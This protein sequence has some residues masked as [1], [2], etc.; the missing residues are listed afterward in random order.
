MAPCIRDHIAGRGLPD[1]PRAAHSVPSAGRSRAASPSTIAAEV[2]VIVAADIAD[3]NGDSQ[4][5]SCAAPA[6]EFQRH[7]SGQGG[8]HDAPAGQAPVLTSRLSKNGDPNEA[9]SLQ[10]RQRRAD[11][12]PARGHRC[13]LPRA[14][15]AGPAQ[16]TTRTSCSRCR[17]S[18]R[19]SKQHR[20]RLR[21]AAAIT[22]TATATAM[23]TG[24]PWAPSGRGEVATC[25]RR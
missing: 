6:D 3:V 24:H 5:A 16:P 17:P 2:A 15:A 10:R 11:A 20:E 4:S 19:R 25:G 23:P 14:G 21:L 7:C 12:R 13:R 22:A 18:T 9:V 8:H 1:Q